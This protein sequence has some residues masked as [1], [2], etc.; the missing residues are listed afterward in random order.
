MSKKKPARS[1]LDRERARRRE[2]D[3]AK[4]DLRLVRS[5]ERGESPPRGGTADAA[6][7]RRVVPLGSQA[8]LGSSSTGA[9]LAGQHVECMWCGSSVEVKARG[10]LPKF[11]SAT[12]RH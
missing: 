5:A 12:C 3:P 4:A 6:S 11:C 7:A 2:L 10:P 1:G 8:D 9:R